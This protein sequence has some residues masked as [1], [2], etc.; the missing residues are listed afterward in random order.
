M[1]QTAQAVFIVEWGSAIPGGYS[2][3]KWSLPEGAAGG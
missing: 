1:S 3:L 2:L